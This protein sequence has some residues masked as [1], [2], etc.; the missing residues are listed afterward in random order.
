MITSGNHAESRMGRLYK[1]SSGQRSLAMLPPPDVPSLL[2]PLPSLFCLFSFPFPPLSFFSSSRKWQKSTHTKVKESRPK[3]PGAPPPSMPAAAKPA[4]ALHDAPSPP[5][6]FAPPF[7]LFFFFPFFF[8]SPVDHAREGRRR[9]ER[10]D[11][12]RGGTW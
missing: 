6:R 9:K 7:P 2:S 4:G 11:H 3:P 1:V 8:F 5:L 10:N 12:L